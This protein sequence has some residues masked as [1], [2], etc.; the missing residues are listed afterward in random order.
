MLHETRW[1]KGVYR[2][3]G[4]T[5]RKL[6]WAVTGCISLKS[7]PKL[8]QQMG[9]TKTKVQPFLLCDKKD[10]RVG[11]LP[12]IEVI[13]Q[14]EGHLITKTKQKKPYSALYSFQSVR[15]RNSQVICL[16]VISQTWLSWTFRGYLPNLVKLDIQ[17]GLCTQPATTI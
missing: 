3:E 1:P 12:N 15:N 2:Q 17:N 6:W 4:Q 11:S 8:T 5:S 10:T 14:E 13:G 9:K 7:T 16:K